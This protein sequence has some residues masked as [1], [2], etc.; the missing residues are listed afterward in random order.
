VT[1]QKGKA[2]GTRQKAKGRKPSEDLAEQGPELFEE[3]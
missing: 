2:E 3:L 1:R